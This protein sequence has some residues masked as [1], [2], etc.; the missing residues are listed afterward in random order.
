MPDL[1]K[2]RQVIKLSD[3]DSGDGTVLIYRMD[4]IYYLTHRVAVSAI[5]IAVMMIINKC[6]KLKYR[7][8][9][10]L[11][12]NGLGDLDMDQADAIVEKLK[13]K[14]GPIELAIAF[15]RSLKIYGTGTDI[16]AVEW[17]SMMPNMVSRK[18]ARAK[19]R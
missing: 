7:R 10:V 13:D 8:K 15:V 5:V 19:S 9:I 3:T 6:K 11:V 16:A 18:R 1:R 14:D 12:T 17:T 4:H 2:L